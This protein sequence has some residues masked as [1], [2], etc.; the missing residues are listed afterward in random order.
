MNDPSTQVDARIPSGPHGGRSIEGDRMLKALASGQRDSRP[1]DRPI[2]EEVSWPSRRA[3]TLIELLV[4]IVIFTMLAIAG[5]NEILRARITANEQR[6]LTDTPGAGAPS[7]A[8]TLL[9]N[10]QAYQVA[11]VRHFL[12]DER[13]M[14]H[15]TTENRDATTADPAI[16]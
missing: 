11:G 13:M 14:I 1:Q 15:A 10:P 16:P 3:F 8:F 2:P 12:I 7:I 9:G 6:T 4:V 5:I